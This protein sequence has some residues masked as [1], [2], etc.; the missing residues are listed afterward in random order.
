MPPSS[1][2]YE[3]ARV[4]VGIDLGGTKVR[5]AIAREHDLVVLAEVV[6][7]TTGDGGAA[8]VRQ[9]ADIV[10]GLAFDCQLAVSD[11][12]A[13]GV[14][15]PGVVDD[16]GR[17]HLSSNISGLSDVPLAT[18]LSDLLDVPVV[19]D[20]DVNAAARGE[21][22]QGVAQGCNSFA[23]LSV[24]TG[25]G[26]GVVINGQ[27]LRGARGA[28]G[29]IAYLPLGID[30]T[31]NQARLSGSLEMSAAAGGMRRAVADLLASGRTSSL[32]SS[33]DV[34]KIFAAA[35][36]GDAVALDVFDGVARLLAEAVLSVAV[37]IDPEIIVLTGGV[38]SEP[39]LIDRVT[40]Q[41]DR[42]APHPVTVLRSSLGHRCGVV[43]AIA[44]ALSSDR[45]PQIEEFN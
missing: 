5:A 43:G 25:I 31:S 8:L 1:S 24:G 26:L 35:E 17:F 37:I 10:R 4:V 7:P 13:I 39:T 45:T 14:G 19:V 32:T 6:Q 42:M 15:S 36:S 44:I 29:E 12:A 3:H 16:T 9:L 27:L 18:A 38:G 21:Q 30:P 41:L 40:Q 22:W 11:L 28:A 34:P 33:C 23:V 2:E 20:N